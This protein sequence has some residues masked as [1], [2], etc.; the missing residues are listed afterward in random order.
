MGERIR[1]YKDEFESAV[2][3]ELVSTYSVHRLGRLKMGFFY[4]HKKI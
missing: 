3:Y 2:T 1:I 4:Y